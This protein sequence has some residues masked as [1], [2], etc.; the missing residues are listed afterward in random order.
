MMRPT[1]RPQQEREKKNPQPPLAIKIKRFALTLPLGHPF[2][3][4][5]VIANN[6]YFGAHNFYRRSAGFLHRAVSHKA[7]KRG[8]KTNDQ[9]TVMSTSL[10]ARIECAFFR[11]AEEERR[12]RNLGLIW[13]L[14]C[15]WP[16]GPLT[17]T[18]ARN[19]L[20]DLPTMTGKERSSRFRSYA[21]VPFFMHS[22]TRCACED[23]V[24]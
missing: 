18:T 4:C 16:A 11:S 15:W 3:R 8:G 21:V 23:S 14:E 6:Y 12:L 20:V 7:E 9:W 13:T 10:I 2:L 19:S 5:Q 17:R 22:R 24:M 1:A